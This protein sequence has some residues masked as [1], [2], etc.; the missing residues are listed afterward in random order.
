MT[1][2]YIYKYARACEAVY[3]TRD[4]AEILRQRKTSVRYSTP[5]GIRGLICMKHGAVFASVDPTLP[6][7]VKR[8][9]EAK[10]LAHS[11]LHRKRLEA[12]ETFEEPSGSSS[13]SAAEREADIFAA[14][15]LIPDGDIMTLYES[16]MSENRIVSSFGTM[17]EVVSH[18]FFSMRSR[19]IAFGED[20][21]R[22]D[23]LKRCDLELFY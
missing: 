10:L 20:C 5:Q 16:G 22:A 6:E 3:G 19:G 7:T 21:R 13:L 2:E 14:E 12:G 15:L 9:T 4:P 18:K 11:L 23:F 1:A 8:I 17:R